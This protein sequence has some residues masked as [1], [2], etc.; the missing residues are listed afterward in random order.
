MGLLSRARR[1][2]SFRAATFGGAAA[3]AGLRG[4]LGRA[5][6]LRRGMPASLRPS[7][8]TVRP[9]GDADLLQLERQ[10]F[11]LSNLM[12]ISREI[13]GT[14]RLDEL[15]TIFILT[16]MGQ[17]GAQKAVLYLRDGD[18][19]VVRASRGLDEGMVLPALGDDSALVR[20]VVQ[21]AMV[22]RAEVFPVSECELED[23]GLDAHLVAVLSA[24][25]VLP[26][27]NKGE[28]LAFLLLGERCPDQAWTPEETGFLASLSD[29]GSMALANARL[30]TE[31]ETR[32]NRLSGL[33]EISRVINSSSQAD[34]ILRLASE[35][36]ATG[37]SV[38]LAAFLGLSNQDLVW[39]AGIG[40][41]EITPGATC[42]ELF[43]SAFVLGQALP[44]EEYGQ[45]PELV[46]VFGQDAVSRANMALLVPL[47]AAGERVGILAILGIEGRKVDSVSREECEL[48]SIIGSQFAPPLLVARTIRDRERSLADPFHPWLALL[49]KEALRA[50]EFGLSVGVCEFWIE[51]FDSAEM[52]GLARLA[53][54]IGHRLRD[55]IDVKHPV[56]RLGADAWAIVLSGVPL[57]DQE[58]ILDCA[59]KEMLLMLDQHGLGERIRLE[60]SQGQI[61]EEYPSAAAWVFRR[62]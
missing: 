62:Q 56:V 33:Y 34:E 61:P 51:G 9:G 42:S 5:S 24:G 40:I 53:E 11:N 43:E 6:A 21:R 50:G 20:A 18:E 45:H 54:D 7:A 13:N 47:V 4:L 2:G 17:S 41:E 52:E 55:V 12:E 32:L 35:T 58:K 15:C 31:L 23:G 46:A 3:Q 16:V 22:Q 10:S 39:L 49:E 25:L 38:S 26:L 36:L 8:E 29:M 59:A 44:V 37:F 57:R 48:F 14:L 1:I 60:R 28:C 30:Y 27:V 19:Y